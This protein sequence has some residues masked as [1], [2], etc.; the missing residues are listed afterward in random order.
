MVG[1]GQGRPLTIQR[2]RWG[3]ASTATDGG[4]PA[5]NLADMPSASPSM[6]RVAGRAF[7]SPLPERDLAALLRHGSRGPIRRTTVPLEPQT[8]VWLGERAGR[9]GA[10][11]TRDSRGPVLR[12]RGS[13]ARALDCQGATLPKSN[14]HDPT[15]TADPGKSNA[16]L[17]YPTPT[18]FFSGRAAAGGANGRE[19]GRGERGRGG[20]GKGKRQG[21]SAGGQNPAPTRWPVR[22]QRLRSNAHGKESRLRAR[23]YAAP[24][25]EGGIRTGRYA[26]TQPQQARNA[27]GIA[28]GKSNAHGPAPSEEQRALARE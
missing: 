10:L 21:G 16:H 8:D 23:A 13:T 15:P 11:D 28:R 25:Q 19:G 5:R 26:Q 20:K 7:A 12:Q 14:A 9:A 22:I 17:Q 3:C 4:R 2:P 6:H 24:Q 27:G 1:Q 18:K